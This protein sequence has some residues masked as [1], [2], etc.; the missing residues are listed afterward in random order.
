MADRDF[1]GVATTTVLVP[2][3]KTSTYTS[4]A[5][6]TQQ[7]EGDWLV[8]LNSAAGTGTTP[9]LAGKMRS[10]PASGGS[11]ADIT[12]ATFTSIDDTAGGSCQII[13]V[14]KNSHDRYVKFVGTIDGTSPSFIFGVNILSRNKAL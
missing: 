2:T 3:A 9:T 10:D 8:V 1:S 5:I 7:F 4:S 11:Y 12:G 13:R 6:D 14:A